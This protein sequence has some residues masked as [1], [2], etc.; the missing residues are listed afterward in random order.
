MRALEKKQNALLESPT[1]S[2]KSL[3]LLCS[4]LAWQKQIQG[5]Y[6]LAACGRL[7]CVSVCVSLCVSA[8]LVPR[9]KI[10][11]GDIQ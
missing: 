8:S 10:G 7:V 9:P 3:A 6:M 5:I 4:C 11:S 1:G 2:G